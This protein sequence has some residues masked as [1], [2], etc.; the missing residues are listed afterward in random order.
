MSYAHRTRLAYALVLSQIIAIVSLES[1]KLYIPTAA[2][3]RGGNNTTAMY[4]P[5]QNF[6][7]IQSDIRKC[8]RI[9]FYK[10]ISYI[11]QSICTSAFYCFDYLDQLSLSMSFIESHVGQPSSAYGYSGVFS[12]GS[13]VFA[14]L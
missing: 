14:D 7:I 2:L 9:P 1:E 6:Y 11:R 4:I 12:R 8:I 10:L 13:L 3:T 5:S